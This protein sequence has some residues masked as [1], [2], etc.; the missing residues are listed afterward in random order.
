MESNNLKSILKQVKKHK[1]YS[2]IADEVVLTEINNYLEENPNTT[3]DKHTVKQVRKQLHLAYAS[4]QTKKKKKIS[5]YLD[6]LKQI[7]S[8]KPVSQNKLIEIT[9]QLLSTTLSSKERLPDYPH[10]YKQ[11]FKI[12]KKPKTIADLGSGFNPFSYP[13]MNLPK[14]NYYAYDINETDISNLNNYFKIM[15]PLGLS[16][17]AAISNL[18]DINQISNLPST[19]II[20]LFKLI[21]IIDIENHKPS[22]QLITEI[23]KQK[24][25]KFI[26]SSFATKTLT[27]RQMNKPNRKWF[28]LM[29]ERNNLKHKTIKTN[30][31]I[32][33]IISK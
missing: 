8:K 9:N 19:D 33:Y 1:K 25:A 7:I 5:L 12:T 20:F 28:E 32:F 3:A 10:I 17:K 22:E 29:L 31:E 18:R 11:I 14:L 30:N 4:F 23:F 24:K 6:D 15:K 2:S 26:I 27:R 16:G 21:D 13:F